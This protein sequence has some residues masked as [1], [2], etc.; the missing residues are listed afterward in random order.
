M[1]FITEGFLELAIESCPERTE[2]A[3]TEFRLD[4]LTELSGHEFNSLSEPTL[5]SYKR[6]LAQVM[7]LER[8]YLSLLLSKKRKV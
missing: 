7:T 8:V 4:P 6:N 5:N 3:T 2:P 1:V